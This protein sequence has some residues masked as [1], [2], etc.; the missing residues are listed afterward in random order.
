MQMG[1]G[2]MKMLLRRLGGRT[3]CLQ[4]C[5]V[6]A[7]YLLVQQAPSFREDARRL[8]EVEE[9]GLRVAA[10]L[11]PGAVKFET[12]ESALQVQLLHGHC[13]RVLGPFTPAPADPPYSTDKLGIWK[14]ATEHVFCVLPA[15]HGEAHTEAQF[16]VSVPAKKHGASGEF[17]FGEGVKVGLRPNLATTAIWPL[18]AGTPSLGL[19]FEDGQPLLG[20]GLKIGGGKDAKETPVV[21]LRQRPEA[22]MPMDIQFLDASLG[23]CKRDE[24]WGGGEAR[25]ICRATDH[26][27]GMVDLVAACRSCAASGS[28]N[29]GAAMDVVRTVSGVVEESSGGSRPWVGWSSSLPPSG[30]SQQWTLSLHN[31]VPG[32]LFSRP[33]QVAL[34]TG[35]GNVMWLPSA[36]AASL[37]RS[38]GNI[39]KQGM[40][41][42]FFGALLLGSLGSSPWSG[43]LPAANAAA[44]ALQFMGIV[45]NMH[46]APPLLRVLCSPLENME[47]RDIRHPLFFM[48]VVVLFHTFA[49]IRHLLANGSG[50]ASALPYGLYFGTWELRTIGFVALPLSMACWRSCF[51]ALLYTDGEG[52]DGLVQFSPFLGGVLGGGIL[53]LLLAVVVWSRHKVNSACKEGAVICTHLPCCEEQ[54]VFVDRCCDQLRSMPLLMSKR[55]RLLGN[56]TSSPGWCVS[57]PVASIQELEHLGEP[58]V[59]AGQMHLVASTGSWQL[60]WPAG[61]WRGKKPDG[62]DGGQYSVVRQE[63]RDGPDDGVISRAMSASASIHSMRLDQDWDGKDSPSLVMQGQPV[64]A[65]TKFSYQASTGLRGGPSTALVGVACLPWIDTA[66]PA[67]SLRQL[68]RVL[69]EVLLRCNVGQLQGPL[70]AG[71]L[72]VCF[73]WGTAW[74]LR[75]SYDL[76]LRIYLGAYAA[77]QS[78]VLLPSAQTSL[79]LLNA[80]GI[81]ALAAYLLFVQKPYVHYL[82]NMALTA[83][84]AAVGLCALLH[85]TAGQAP[86]IEG[87][88]VVALV[89]AAA[90]PLATLLLAIL[91]S[92]KLWWRWWGPDMHDKVLPRTVRGW[93]EFANLRAVASG[94]GA[95]ADKQWG[96]WWEIEDD[97]TDSELPRP[98]VAGINKVNV[99]LVAMSSA[100]SR[101]APQLL[102]LP[103]DVRPQLVHTRLS[104]TTGAG[105]GVTHLSSDGE[106]VRLPIATQLLFQA[107]RAGQSARFA[108]EFAA[109]R[110]IPLAAL[111]SKDGG[112]LV[113]AEDA[114]NGGAHWSEVVRSFIDLTNPALMQEVEKIISNHLEEKSRKEGLPGVEEPLVAVV[115]VVS[116]SE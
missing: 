78:E 49:V 51:Q 108:A 48:A 114:H 81:A 33:V 61:P 17:G 50:S 84:L 111:V 69:G 16:L 98:E 24:M 53:V 68:H 80:V 77:L 66:V 39:L 55:S 72:A 86:H 76:L 7:L 41:I 102:E 103:A 38:A 25:V 30:D 27:R 19:K 116:P 71:R 26:K 46:G 37:A 89:V 100:A 57:Q 6:A 9:R 83:A 107:K 56:W 21:V 20:L 99:T 92:V 18:Q 60:L 29:S 75:W 63:S 31:D 36:W 2:R 11:L 5:L 94:A 43:A 12:D 10:P 115:E 74:P 79:H 28:S 40:V 54:V 70:T 23:T 106:R 62:G 44:L 96:A 32:Q 112:R 87:L 101:S 47:D 64:R 45:G 35:E 113:Y 104:A 15:S 3:L 34:I 52:A 82:D 110:T 8:Q 58:E 109:A 1:L 59:E 67:S 97:G 73:D 88:V 90:V 65:T 93:G 105:G 91:L 95:Q 42:A 13:N 14:A 85:F 22:E 4:A